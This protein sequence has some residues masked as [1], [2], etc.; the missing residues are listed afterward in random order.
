MKK[1]T[2]ETARLLEDQLMRLAGSERSGYWCGRCVA[3]VAVLYT[4][5]VISERQQ[6]ALMELTERVFRGFSGSFGPV[7]QTV[8]QI[9]EV[10]H[11]A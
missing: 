3:T 1:L 6:A 5:G 9:L 11:D 2:S 8:R 4:E 7:L 10:N